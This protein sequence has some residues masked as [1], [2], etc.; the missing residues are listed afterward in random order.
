MLL[1]RTGALKRFSAA[2]AYNLTAQRFKSY[3]DDFK[4]RLKPGQYT[5][6]RCSQ[7]EGDYR[8]ES[9]T[10]GREHLNDDGIRSKRY[11]VKEA[12]A[13]GYHYH[14]PIDSKGQVYVK[15]PNTVHERGQTWIK[16]YELPSME[17]TYGPKQEDIPFY[18]RVKLNVWGNYNL[19]MKV[20]FLF[21]YLP[22][23][24]VFGVCIPVYTINFAQEEVIYTTMTVKVTGRQ[25]Y[26][27]Y[28]VESPTDEDEDEDEDDEDDDDE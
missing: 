18:P 6:G 13:L 23:I 17:Y 28:E 16:G 14:P 2:P 3:Y 7:S 10:I 12:D 11:T 27:V 21:F 25:W 26:W 1:S 15:G 24:I 20:E 9:K 8:Q 5:H 22:T 4:D 19:V